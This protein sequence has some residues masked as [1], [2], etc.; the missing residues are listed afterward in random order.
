M[1]RLAWMSFVLVACGGSPAADAGSA[2]AGADSGPV[3][4]G[5]PDR[6]CPPEV[7]YS[8]NPCEGELVCTYEDADE[9]EARCVGGVWSAVATC[10]G[11]VLPLA[12][13]CLEPFAGALHGA[14]VTMGPPGAGRP[15]EEGEDV[16]LIVG[17]QGSPMLAFELHV[18]GVESPPECVA[19]TIALAWDGGSE[20]A[21]TMPVGVRLHCGSS[22][23]I[24]LIPP[25][26]PCDGEAHDLHVRV[27]V[28][29][30]GEAS[31]RLR[32]IDDGC[33][34]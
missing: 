5:E 9:S 24:L 33:R 22:R 11:C 4:C 3:V 18:E 25:G 10:P 26:V 17:A 7:P 19:R 8:G 13:Y 6:E 31:A 2:D 34:G 12:E 30:I 20:I 16:A 21:S 1:L 23:T 27:P 14:T 28:V 29:G 15:F 32:I